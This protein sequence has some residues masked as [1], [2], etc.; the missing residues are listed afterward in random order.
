MHDMT[1]DQSHCE[2][3]SLRT[4]P[5][6]SRCRACLQK[7]VAAERA[8]R[9]AR[10][11]LMP[12]KRK[13][14]ER[15]RLARCVK[16]HRQREPEKMAVRAGRI[17]RVCQI[18]EDEAEHQRSRLRHRTPAEKHRMQ[19]RARVARF[20]ARYPERHNARELVRVAIRLGSRSR[21]LLP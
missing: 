19:V 5:A 6:L 1:A 21:S 10:I 13:P 16:C 7:A 15:S 4:W 17:T 3:G 20:R 9:A 2:C 14:A 12:V 18:C 8:T 11:E